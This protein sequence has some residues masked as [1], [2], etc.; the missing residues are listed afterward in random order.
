M[1]T[2]YIIYYITHKSITMACFGI[3]WLSFAWHRLARLGLGFC[4]V[5]E[6][7]APRVSACAGAGKGKGRSDQASLRTKPSL[8]TTRLAHLI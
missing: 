6:S 3:G 4:G 1:H 2:C 8:L 5:R 7:E